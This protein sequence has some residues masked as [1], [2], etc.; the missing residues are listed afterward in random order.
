M[1][2]EVFGDGKTI[3]NKFDEAYQ[4]KVGT[5]Q[6]VDVTKTPIEQ[7]VT[8]VICENGA[9][10]IIIEKPQFFIDKIGLCVE[11]FKKSKIVIK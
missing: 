1:S 6:L 8:I 2:Q 9:T 10:Q 4:Q 3:E 11:D 7:I 5:T